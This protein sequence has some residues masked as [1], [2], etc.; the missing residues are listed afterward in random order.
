MRQLQTTAFV[1]HHITCL[2]MLN[3]ETHICSLCVN[4]THAPE[5]LE[6]NNNQKCVIS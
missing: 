5:L 2:L 1:S 6:E 4:A 3:S